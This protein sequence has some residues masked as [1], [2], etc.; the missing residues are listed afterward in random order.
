MIYNTNNKTEKPL[1]KE[2]KQL[3]L[4]LKALR[5][6][7][8]Y[9]Q[10]KA[11]TL[12]GISVETLAKYEKGLTYPDIPILKKIEEVYETKYDKINFF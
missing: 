12:I 3:K 4:T 11:A 6:N 1:R 2:V 10:E 5:I 9:T 7:K 8:G